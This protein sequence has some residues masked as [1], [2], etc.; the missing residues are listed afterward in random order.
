M[1][2]TIT[3]KNDSK[4]KKNRILVRNKNEIK[5]TL[6][7]LDG[8]VDFDFDIYEEIIYKDLLFEY[9]NRNYDYSCICP[10]WNES[11]VVMLKNIMTQICLPEYMEATLIKNGMPIPK[12]YIHESNENNIMITFPEKYGNLIYYCALNPKTMNE[13][14][15]VPHFFTCNK[16]SDAVKQAAISTVHLL[17]V[18]FNHSLLLEN[19]AIEFIDLFNPD[20]VFFVQIVPIKVKKNKFWIVFNIIQNQR[21]KVTGY[22]CLR[23]ISNLMYKKIISKNDKVFFLDK[24]EIKEGIFLDN[25]NQHLNIE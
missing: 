24:M 3:M 19:I 25:K 13:G 21:S 17:G 2:Y 15:R 11:D 7:C 18:P 12:E 8:K 10:K 14:K 9:E 22:V 16:I 20:I 5:M 1:S 23:D 4:C 6:F